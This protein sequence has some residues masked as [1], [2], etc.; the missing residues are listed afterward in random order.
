MSHRKINVIVLGVILIILVVAIYLLSTSST[1][2]EIKIKSADGQVEMLFPK[3]ALANGINVQDLKIEAVTAEDIPV[4]LPDVVA[5][6]QLSPDGT[7][8][9][10]PGQLTL[11][12]PYTGTVLP[13]LHLISSEGLIEPLQD[14]EFTLDRDTQTLT[15]QGP[16]EHFST[17]VSSL[18]HFQISISDPA[19]YN[20]GENFDVAV[21]VN[22]VHPEFTFDIPGKGVGRY[23]LIG[24]YILEG[25][26]FSGNA[27]APIVSPAFVDNLPEFRAVPM[28]ESYNDVVKF[29]CV[30]AGIDR[31]K[32]KITI[33]YQHTI[34]IDNF[35]D[36]LVLWAG[37][38]LFGD[39]A[40]T[41]HEKNF[42]YSKSFRCVEGNSSLNAPTS[43]SNQPIIPTNIN[44]EETASTTDTPVVD[45]EPKIKTEA[46]HY[47]SEY[48]LSVISLTLTPLATADSELKQL[49][50]VLAQP[51]SAPYSY[52][53]NVNLSGPQGWTCNTDQSASPPRLT[54]T[55]G[56]AL[57]R[58]QKSVLTFFLSERLSDIPTALELS[59]PSAEGVLMLP[60]ELHNTVA[61]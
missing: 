47:I 11:K 35:T 50:V 8:F 22:V 40:I 54:C 18:S 45:T 33:Q 36:A 44:S 2:D 39:E 55:G 6:Y 19:T 32:Y 59:V 30:K 41:L 27:A 5:A 42:I 1:N 3:T 7:V 21:G 43:N 23:T 14:F 49:S 57:A 16:I 4:H 48:N 29:T 31:L 34:S 13:E 37:D 53:I 10:E 24:D 52:D 9:K 51:L 56:T 17:L 25:S 20:V 60:T 15:A 38:L 46:E 28:V 58:R 26:L 12:I 61:Q